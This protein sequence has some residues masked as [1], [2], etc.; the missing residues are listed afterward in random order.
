[1]QCPP[2]LVLVHWIDAFDSANGWIALKDYE[3]QTQH[4]FQVGF[5]VDD[6]LDGHLSL[7]GSWCPADGKDAVED[8]GMIT[9]IPIGMV[10]CVVELP[11]PE[12]GRAYPHPPRFD[13][14]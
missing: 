12:W 6:V 11:V 3:P 10:Q 5:V 14:T 2:R 13:A 7:T 4:V 8:V 1:M 9:H